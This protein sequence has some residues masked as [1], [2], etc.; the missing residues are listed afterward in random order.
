MRGKDL[1]WQEL[2]VYPI[3]VCEREAIWKV[4]V[5]ESVEAEISPESSR[6]GRESQSKLKFYL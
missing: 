2:L 1:K 3:H 6:I 5:E 4:V